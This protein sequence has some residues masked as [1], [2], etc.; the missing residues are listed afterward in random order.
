MGVDKLDNLVLRRDTLRGNLIELLRQSL[1][2]R[3]YNSIID[4]LLPAEVGIERT[5]AFPRCHSDI[6]HRSAI[7]TILSKKLTGDVNEFLSCLGY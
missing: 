7:E 3:L 5:A 4:I 1:Q 6:I 2:L